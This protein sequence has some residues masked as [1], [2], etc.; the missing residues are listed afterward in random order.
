MSA[1]V[2]NSWIYLEPVMNSPDILKHLSVEGSK[3][4]VLDDQWKKI[5][6]FYYRNQIVI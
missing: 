4:F 2:Q 5:T 3:F 6:S 1:K